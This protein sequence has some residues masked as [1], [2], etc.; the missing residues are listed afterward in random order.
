M[1]QHSIPSWPGNKSH[2][3]KQENLGW[4]TNLKEAKS[5][6]EVKSRSHVQLFVTPWTVAYQAP[7]SMEFSRQEYWSGVPFPSP[8]DI[9]KPGIETGSAALR[10]E[11]IAGR[12]FTVWAVREAWWFSEASLKIKQNFAKLS[13]FCLHFKVWLLWINSVIYSNL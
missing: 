6:F 8:G 1:G 5:F 11:A 12:H 4:L 13:K 3:L 7:P 9:P 10:T 2:R